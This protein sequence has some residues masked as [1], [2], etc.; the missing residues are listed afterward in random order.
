MPEERRWCKHC[1][2]MTWHRREWTFPRSPGLA[3]IA[4]LALPLVVVRSV[5][6]HGV[7]S[8]GKA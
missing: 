4:L 8:A 7:R 6:L 3:L 2:R 1:A 5:G